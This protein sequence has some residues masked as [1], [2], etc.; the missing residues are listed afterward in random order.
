MLKYKYQFKDIRRTNITYES[1][2]WQ[3]QGN[4]WENQKGD[5]HT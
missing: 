5:I 2:T 3:R 4:L 1:K